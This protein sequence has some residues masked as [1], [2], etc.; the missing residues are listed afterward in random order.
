MLNAN[1]WQALMCIPFC[2]Y[3]KQGSNELQ[4]AFD[5]AA[6]HPVVY[7]RLLLFALAMV[8]GQSFIYVMA[9]RYGALTVT[10]IT[11]LRKFFSVLLSAFPP[12][13]GMSNSLVPAQGIGIV[14]VFGSKIVSKYLGSKKKKTE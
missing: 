9:R 7:Q 1:F 3:P 12:P 13:L 6:R 4:L 10:L 2:L 8:C 5:F 11:T 14:L